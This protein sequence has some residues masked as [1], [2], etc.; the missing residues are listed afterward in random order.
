VKGASVS[1]RV[2]DI[3]RFEAK[4]R[5]GEI[6][7]HAAVPLAVMFAAA[8]VAQTKIGPGHYPMDAMFDAWPPEYAANWLRSKTANLKRL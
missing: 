5:R 6:P 7:P 8:R 3:A 4:A 2:G 1:A